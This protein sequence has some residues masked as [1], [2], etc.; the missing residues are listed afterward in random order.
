MKLFGVEAARGF[1]A[2]LVV[3]VH[4]S[5]MLGAAKYFGVLPFAGLFRFGHAGVD[6]F[7]VLSGFIIYF[8]HGGDVGRPERLASYAWKR[9]VRIYPVYWAVLAIMGALLAY[10]PTVGRTEQQV[11]NIL[12]TV[13]LIPSAIGPFLDVAWSL[14]HEIIFYL[15]FGVLFLNRRAGQAVLGAWGLLV[16]WNIAVTM[17][18][19][20][21]FFDGIAGS[22]VFRIFNI[23]F[24]FGMAVAHAVRAG[25]IWRPRTLIAVGLVLF[26]GD[27]LVESWGP[28]MPGEWPPRHLVY[29]LGAALT[30]Y[31]LA[32]AESVGRLRVPAALVALG[33]ASY[34]IYLTHV[35]VVMVLQQMLLRLRPWVW[36]TGEI[37][38][39][40]F[41]AAA[42][43][44][45]MA[46][47]R[48]VE[49]PLLRWLRRRRLVAAVS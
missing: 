39:V 3:T 4:A 13:F 7:F 18:T 6:F 27:G 22:I 44:A 29:A 21:P 28:A 42:T 30:L 1:A 45:G 20:Q 33:T 10:S 40:I 38:F 34:S 16:A 35:I 43:F 46:F 19:G 23:E 8:V 26:I 12:T 37:W 49:Q 25:W 24:F 17:V 5:S 9:F 48:V 14:K 41:V 2:L 31:G 32:A 15:L 47:C 11:G 36:L